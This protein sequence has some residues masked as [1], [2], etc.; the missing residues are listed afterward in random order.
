[1]PT[2]EGLIEQE[3]CALI[4]KELGIIGAKLTVPGDTGYPDRIFWLPGGRPLLI[5][6]KQPGEAPEPKQEYHIRRLR[7]LGYL[8]E[9]HDNATDALRA[10][11]RALDPACIPKAGRKVLADAR[12]RWAV[13]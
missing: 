9:V 1:M 7:A 2:P 8:V 3:A 5:E 13:C 12:R 11:L 10:V 6:F 4:L